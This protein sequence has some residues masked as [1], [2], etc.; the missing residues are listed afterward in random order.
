MANILV[1]YNAT[2]T[3]TQTVFEHLQAFARFSKHSYSFAHASDTTD[4]TLDL[5]NFDGLAIHYT[6]RLPFN[7]LSES[8]AEAIAAFQGHKFLFIQDEYDHTKRAWHWI[9]CL[10]L[11]TVFTVVPEQNIS[12][13]Y[14]KEQFPDVNF[15]NVLTGYVPE[16][17]TQLGV[18]SAPSQRDI[19]VGYRGRP[20]AARYGQLGKEKLNIGKM[21]RA[22]AEANNHSVD[23]DW[24]ESAR[25]YSDQWY[26]FVASTRATLGTESGANIFD[27]D[28]DLD[29]RLTEARTEHP[30]LDDQALLEQLGV[31]DEPGLMNQISPRVFEAIALRTV[32]VLFKG[33]YSGVLKPDIHYIPLNKDGGNLE[34]VFEKLQDGP[35][36]DAM[37]ERAYADIIASGDHSYHAFLNRVDAFTPLSEASENLEL[38]DGVTP[39]PIKAEPPIILDGTF[40]SKLRFGGRMQIWRIVFL[41]QLALMALARAARILPQNVQNWLRV[42]VKRILGL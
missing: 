27:W 26:P 28:G 3:Y 38:P 35:A 9:K 15:V 8:W 29:A 6:V 12:R 21:V 4:C 31:K 22:Y 30:D 16:N 14:P 40:W 42:R 34:T 32:L 18:P 37:A 33:S 13:I 2:Q 19:L 23:I 20:L 17:L 25:I 39:Q 41:K 1:L 36:L 11:N 24:R 10:R 7:Q 5:S